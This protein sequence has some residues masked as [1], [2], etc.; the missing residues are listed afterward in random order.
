MVPVPAPCGPAWT[1]RA[2]KMRIQLGAM[3]DGSTKR[4]AMGVALA[5]L[6]GC[7]NPG[8]LQLG[9]GADGGA[10]GSEGSTSQPDGNETGA[11]STGLGSTG[12][13]PP[14]TDPRCWTVPMD[15]PVY[16][17]AA[18]GDDESGQ[19][20]ALSP[21]G[22]MSYAVTQVPDGSVID[23]G[24]G[25]YL[26]AQELVGEFDVGITVRAVPAYQARLRHSGPVVTLARAQG[27]TVE[28]FDI[29][30]LGGGAERFVVH[31][32]DDLGAPGGTT[33]STRIVLRDNIIHDS[34]NDD[35]LRIDTGTAGITV[36][37][38]LFYNQGASNEHVDVN[39]ASDV[40]LRG[41][42][43]FNDFAA[44]GRTN[45][46][47]TASFVAIKDANGAEDD[48][49]GASSIDID[50]NIFMGWQGS[51]AT[52]FVQLAE[53]G[54]PFYEAR[55][56]LVQNNL[57]L[58]NGGDEMRA[59]F[60]CKGARNVV[61]RSNTVV[62]NIPASAFAFRLNVEGQS[63]PNDGVSFFNNIWSAPGGT[64]TDLT[65]TEPVSPLENFVLQT[66]LYWNG[67]QPIPQ[68]ASDTINLDADATAIV[69][70]P[71]IASLPMTNPVWDADSEEFGGGHATFCDAF[72]DLVV[73]HGTPEPNGAAAGNA[74]A[75]ELPALDILGRPRATAD[76]GAVAIPQP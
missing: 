29:A 18:D 10:S 15:A 72:E 51:A 34:F 7:S 30:H 41:N 12:M 53:N 3:W 22:T 8:V 74:L 59:P 43:F 44:S 71:R 67:D 48:V 66:N 40:V 2:V 68:D 20:T 42:I 19:G 52:N 23:V 14:V 5:A 31:V 33:F 24:P 21:W 46:R 75:S 70:D 32:R 11:G 26:G 65:D 13:E 45:A 16:V 55:D 60:G 54:H 64:M 4:T 56:V 58:G 69:A 17:V 63:P 49:S 73:R 62:G 57:M 27:I 76:L 61:V 37:G 6:A 38:N 47:D 28:G 1:V 9:E 50:G 35:L 39:A 36:E 25:E